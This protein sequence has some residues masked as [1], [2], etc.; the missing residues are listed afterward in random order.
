MITGPH[1]MEGAA[2]SCCCMSAY[3]LGSGDEADA[4]L[5]EPENHQ[6]IAR[7]KKRGEKF[8][9]K[10]TNSYLCTAIGKLAE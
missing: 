3:H 7:E 8:C 1:S 4:N 5:S 2:L 9:G 10:E 6:R